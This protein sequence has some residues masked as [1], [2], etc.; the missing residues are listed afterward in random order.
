M[1]APLPA[2]EAMRLDAL[3]RF[4]ILDTDAEAAYDDITRIA[5]YIAGTPISLISLVDEDRQWFKSKIGL[6]ASQTPREYAFCAHAILRPDEPLV[7]ADATHDP[8]F[9]DNPLVTGAPDIRFYMG[10]PLVTVDKHA[11]GTLCV[12]D[13]VPREPA[14]AEIDALAALARQVMSQLEL[15]RLSR[16]LRTI[17][18]ERETHVAELERYRAELEVTNA[19]LLER[20]LRDRLTGRGNRAAFDDRLMDEVYRAK[21]YELPLSLLMVDVDHFKQ[22]NDSFGHPAGDVALKIV[23]EALGN[24]RP[25]DFIARIG[26]EEFAVILPSTGSEVAMITAERLRQ[27]VEAQAF[28]H[29]PVT[30]SIGMAT[31]RAEGSPATLLEIA[32]KAL[33]AAKRSGR[34]RVI[35]A[36]QL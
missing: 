21:R 14:R 9:A 7:V 33:Y 2:D 24:I 8:R 23:A 26:G 5:A 12:I 22:Y 36:D 25:S 28:P 17:V 20:S 32:D 13:R 19:T 6:T 10:A 30:V 16:D 31:L 27:N 35:H 34:N 1:E 4:D 29:R 3:R 18:S 11:I 15:R